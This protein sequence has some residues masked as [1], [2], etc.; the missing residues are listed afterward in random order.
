MSY[1]FSKALSDI[2]NVLTN[3]GGVQDADN[4]RAEWGPSDFDRTHA[5]VTSWVWQLPS[6]FGKRGAGHAIFGGWEVN[7][8]WSMYSG[9]PLQFALSQDRALR[10]QP[11]RPDRI[12]DARLDNGRARADRIT[13]YFDRSAYVPNQTGQFGNA[14][15]AEGQL[16]APGTID[17]TGGI[18]KRFRGLRESH[19]LQFRTELF[20]ALNR[21][22]FSAPGTNPDTGGSYGRITGASDG[23]IIQFGMKYAF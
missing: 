4:R 15:R 11:N 19:T 2:N 17:M 6:P 20:N 9:A 12:K 8:I 13:Q 16:K 14:P 3:N 22:N 7:G 23:R 5:F 10:G 18:H 21:P 1:T